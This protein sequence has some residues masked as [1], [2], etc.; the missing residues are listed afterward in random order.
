MDTTGSIGNGFYIHRDSFVGTLFRAG[1]WMSTVQNG[2]IYANLVWSGTEPVGN[3]I[4]DVGPYHSVLF[5]VDNQATS[6]ERLNKLVPY[7][8]PRDPDNH[9]LIQG[10]QM[11]WTSLRSDTRSTPP[12]N[13]PIPGL[14]VAVWLFAYRDPRYGQMFFIHY[15][16]NNTSQYTYDDAVLGF[17]C[18]TD[19]A[20][21]PYTASQN[22]TAYDSANVISFTY[23]PNQF[24]QVYI[25]GLAP[26]QVP[27]QGKP[28][29][30]VLAHRP[31]YKN[32]L[33]NPDFAEQGLTDVQTCANALHGVSN[34]G[35]PMINPV[36]GHPTRFAYTGNPATLTGWLSHPAGDVRT[37]LSFGPLSISPGQSVPLTLVIHIEYGLS[38]Q[39]AIDQLRRTVENLFESP[40]LWRYSQFNQ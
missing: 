6:Y 31:V 32:N 22:A 18:D 11:I 13:A 33:I 5:G 7:G 12:L 14:D 24:N 19:L 1:L 39:E 28:E 40:E 29:S 8:W 3:Y 20:Y 35:D 30:M 10:D 15:Q 36:S 26:L 9:P 25:V 4:A 34:T 27:G 16:I 2:S 38:L 23:I 21:P 17:Y 37:L